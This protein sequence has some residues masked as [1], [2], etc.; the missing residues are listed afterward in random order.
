MS[1]Q[2]DATASTRT[3]ERA[4]APL[5]VSPLTDLADWHETKAHKARTFPGAG[6]EAEM[7]KAAAV[8]QDAAR[9]LRAAIEVAADGAVTP[10]TIAQAFCSPAHRR[11]DSGWPLVGEDRY[12]GRCIDRAHAALGIC[13]T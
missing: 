3:D 5:F 9:R 10:E 8:H 2:T 7:D 6:R 12:C 13:L 11:A 1:E 4:P